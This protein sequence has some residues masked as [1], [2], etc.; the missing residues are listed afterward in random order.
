MRDSK[1]GET[2]RTSHESRHLVSR[3]KLY[4]SLD[5]ENYSLISEARSKHLGDENVIDFTPR[6]A[7]FVKME[8]VS[9]VGRDSGRDDIAEC[10]AYIGELSLFN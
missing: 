9:T 2:W 7:R 3:Y 6:L 5:G 8:I 1:K 4:S 10:D